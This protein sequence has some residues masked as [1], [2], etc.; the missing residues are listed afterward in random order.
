MTRPPERVPYPPFQVCLF[1]LDSNEIDARHF[2]STADA[3]DFIRETLASDDG[4]SAREQYKFL[5]YEQRN[6]ADGCWVLL[7]RVFPPYPPEFSHE[8]IGGVA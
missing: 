8:L 6:A 4:P 7:A 1:A 3:L 2:E 5:T